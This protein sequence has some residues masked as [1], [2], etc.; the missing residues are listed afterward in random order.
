MAAGERPTIEERY[1]R[2]SRSSDLVLSQLRTGDLDLV[3]AAGLVRHD[4]LGI[5]LIRLQAEF[6]SINRRE[7]EHAA[8]SLTAR[9]LTLMQL[10]SLQPVQE[11]LFAQA[12]R[13]AMRDKQLPKRNWAPVLRKIVGRSLTAWLDPSCH[14]CNGTG[15]VGKRGISQSLCG[16]CDGGRHRWQFDRTEAGH[17]LGRALL[18]DMDA[19]VDNAAHSISQFLHGRRQ[20]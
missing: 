1:I 13:R 2:A 9:V 18:S 14:V 16:Q 20:A 10:R 5:R 4:S 15:L 19:A 7:L 17:Q 3:I 12:T 8:D 6:D 11:Q